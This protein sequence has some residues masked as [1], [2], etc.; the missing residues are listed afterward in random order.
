MAGVSP[1]LACLSIFAAS[2]ANGP[3]DRTTLLIAGDF[4]GRLAPCG[5]TFPMT[6]G[7]RRLATAVAGMRGSGGVFIVN[8]GLIDENPPNGLVGIKQSAIK[9]RALADSLRAMHVDAVNLGEEEVRAGRGTLQEIEQLT[10]NATISTSLEPSA[11]NRLAS[12]TARGP[13]L[14]GGITPSADALAVLTG[15]TPRT[16]DRAARELA[17][18]A[19]RR[20]LAPILLFRGSEASAIALAKAVPELALIVYKGAGSAPVAPEQVGRTTLVTPGDYAKSLVRIEFDGSRFFGYRTVELTPDI[21]DDPKIS[22]FYR[23]YLHEVDRAKLIEQLER[24]KTAAYAGSAACMSC[25]TAAYRK[26][27][28][29]AHH[30]ALADL[31]RQGHARDPD[32]LSCHVTGLSSSIGF[33]TRALTPSLADVTCEGCHGPAKAH[34][35]APRKSKLTK[36]TPISCVKCHSSENSPNFSFARMWPKISHR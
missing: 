17:D 24:T 1:A 31:E 25:H 7:I 32:C 14:I 16:S 28:G 23:D 11:A 19:G 8:G 22:R 15:E 27:K 26:W 13:F 9:A 10:D 6:G 2:L 20:G 35:L 4:Q 3:S 33:K 12:W 30:H 21:A 34:A 5:C 29:S 36:L 18:E